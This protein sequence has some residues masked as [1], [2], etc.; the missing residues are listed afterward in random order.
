ME[1]AVGQSELSEE[2]F[3]FGQGLLA[4][5]SGYEGRHGNVLTRRE[6]R[7]ELMELEDEADIGVA[8]L[9]ELPVL[10]SEDVGAVIYYL[11]AVG[12]VEG[13]GNLEQGGLSGTAWADNGH[14]LRLA[15]L[16]R[17]VRHYLQGAV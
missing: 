7:Q 9:R 17:D 11:S 5:H 12:T 1:Q 10:E 3:R 2:A 16:K 6:L 14:N 15:D 8:E 13:A 4:S